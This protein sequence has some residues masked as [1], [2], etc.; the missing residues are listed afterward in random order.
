MAGGSRDTGILTDGIV[1]K[2]RLNEKMVGG[3]DFGIDY[4]ISV[5]IDEM[6]RRWVNSN[7]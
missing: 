4:I 6:A 7:T 5:L 3:I 2:I 1:R